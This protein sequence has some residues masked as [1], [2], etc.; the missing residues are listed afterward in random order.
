MVGLVCNVRKVNTRVY[1][2]VSYPSPSEREAS[3]YHP[4]TTQHVIHSKTDKYEWLMYYD[5]ILVMCVYSINK[6]MYLGPGVAEI[7]SIYILLF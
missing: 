6:Q 2:R 1:T 7:V 4:A 5:A 3:R